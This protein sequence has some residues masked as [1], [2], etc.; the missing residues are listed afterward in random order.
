[1]KEYVLYKGDKLLAIGTADEIV[2]QL[3]IKKK[4]L[5]FYKSPC[6]KKRGLGKKSTKRRILVEIEDGE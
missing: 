2:K 5:Y 3:G 1:M 4:T 6:Y